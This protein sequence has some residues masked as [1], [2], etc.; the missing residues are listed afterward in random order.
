MRSGFKAANSARVSLFLRLSGCTTFKPSETAAC[1]TGEK[2][3][4]QPDPTDGRAGYNRR[5]LIVIQYQH[6][7]YRHGKTGVPIKTIR[8]FFLR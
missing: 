6:L 5:Y 8:T 1:L 3:V 4:L 2:D 7:Q